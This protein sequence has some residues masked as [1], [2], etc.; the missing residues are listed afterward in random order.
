MPK[1]SLVDSDKIITLMSKFIRDV[2][3]ACYIV[4][5]PV[6][7]MN[8]AL[9]LTFSRPPVICNSYRAPTII[10]AQ[11]E[12]NRIDFRE[13]IDLVSVIYSFTNS[14]SLLGRQ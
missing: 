4:T 9:A 10:A 14:S 5:V 8:D 11:L 2:A 3:I 7:P 12:V 13:V 1:T 6:N